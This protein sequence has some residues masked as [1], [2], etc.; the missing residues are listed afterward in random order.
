MGLLGALGITRPP[1]IVRGPQA[2]KPMAKDGTM[3][4]LPAGQVIGPRF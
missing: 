1:S 2:T 4:A 3:C